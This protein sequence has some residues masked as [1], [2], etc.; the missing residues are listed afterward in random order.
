MWSARDAE[1]VG[2]GQ[3]PPAHIEA[4]AASRGMRAETGRIDAR[5]SARCRAFRADAGRNRPHEKTRLLGALVQR[6]GHRVEMRKRLPAQIR[7]QGRWGSVDPLDAREGALRDLPDRQPAELEARDRTDHRHTRK[8]RHDGGHLA[9]KSRDRPGGRPRAGRSEARPRP[10]HRSQAAALTGL[11]PVAHDSAAMRGK[12]ATG[13]GRGAPRHAMVRTARV[14]R[15]HT[16]VRKTGADR[17]GGAGKPH[18]AV[19]TAIARKRVTVA[20][21]PCKPRLK[22]TSQAA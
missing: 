13:G 11:A 20:N 14:A 5:R 9:L 17:P 1:D 10:D 18:E 21:A 12:R 22:R 16:A 3:R 6:R 19:M 15:L 4:V 8:P 2:T 7:A